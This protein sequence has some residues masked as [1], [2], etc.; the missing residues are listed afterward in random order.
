MN[1]ATGNVPARHIE[2][3][4]ERGLK[5]PGRLWSANAPRALIAVVHGIGEHAARYAALAADLA[6]ASYSVV[7]FDLPGHGEAPGP[8]GDIRS[9]TRLRD[10]LFPAMFT[11]HQ[12]LSDQPDRLPRILLGH[13]LGG[14]FALDC[15]LARPSAISGLIL[16]A[17]GLKSA[18]PPWWKVTLANVARTTAPAVGFPTGLDEGGMSRDPEVVRLRA[19]DPLKHDRISPRLYFDFSE[20]RQRVLRDCRRLSV[21]TL[22]LHGEADRVVDPAGSTELAEAAPRGMVKLVTYPGAYHELF[23]DPARDDAIRDVISWLS[24]LRPRLMR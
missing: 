3:E 5:L 7:A 17:P 11:A 2:I 14:V 16:S 18:L 15:A 13:S 1:P 8:R 19:E 20:A 4:I 9:W 22:V 23:N 12:S 6:S 24:E 10:Q 21:P